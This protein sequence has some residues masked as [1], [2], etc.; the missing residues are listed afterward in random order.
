MNRSEIEQLLPEIFQRA[1][2]PGTLLF[3]L[4]ELMA[5]L[6]APSERILDE[7]DHYL[8]PFDAP[9]VFVPYLASWL[10]L[11]RVFGGVPA[12]Y[13]LET[14]QA[15]FPGGLN[16]LRN[17]TAEAVFLARWRGTKTG[18]TR[19]LEVATGMRGFDVSEQTY[20]LYGNPI[21]F[22]ILV[23]APRAAEAYA[24]LLIR[25]VEQEKPAYVTYELTYID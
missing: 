2:V 17:L 1:A 8:D 7:V 23:R 20:D 25:I 16:Q 22:H 12:Q 21:P 3:A 14:V 15:L 5:I 24:P 4:L 6:Q 11:E 18:L 10:D 19:F 9:D 13:D